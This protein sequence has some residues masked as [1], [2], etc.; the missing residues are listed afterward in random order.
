MIVNSL[1]FN[2][3]APRIEELLNNARNLSNFALKNNEAFDFGIDFLNKYFDEIA[4]DL[5]NSTQQ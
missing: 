1:N 4:N 3:S 5:K 2:E